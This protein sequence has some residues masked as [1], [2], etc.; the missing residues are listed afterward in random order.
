MNDNTESAYAPSIRRPKG[1]GPIKASGAAHHSNHLVGISLLDKVLQRLGE[2][3][4]AFFDDMNAAGQTKS[5]C[6]GQHRE[7]TQSASVTLKMKENI[8]LLSTI[9]Y[10]THIL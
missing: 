2:C 7:G 1:G 4:Q 10:A 5:L 8:D 6:L 3:E 9:I